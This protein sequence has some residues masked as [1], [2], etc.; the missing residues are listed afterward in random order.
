VAT[1]FGRAPLGLQQAYSS[2]YN[3]FL[4]PLF[5]GLYF[6]ILLIVSQPRW[7]KIALSLLLIVLVGA[8]LNGIKM[9]RYELNLYSFKKGTDAWQTCY[10]IQHDA[11]RCEEMTGFKIYPQFENTNLEEKL[12]LLQEKELNLFRP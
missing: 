6:F 2:R 1:A 8:Y 3:T 9:A 7:Q 10:K 12:R 5:I 11:R 4:I